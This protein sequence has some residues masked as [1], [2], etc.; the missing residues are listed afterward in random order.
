MRGYSL[1]GLGSGVLFGVMDGIINAN[2][3]GQRLYEVY[4]PI[5]RTSINAPAGVV[6]DLLYGFVL[7]GLFLLLH[8]SLP[9]KSG[10]MKGLSF[11]LLAWF[12]RVLMNAA[13]Q[14]IMFR[15][16]TETLAYTLL[17]GLGEMLILGVLYG[18]TL[19]PTE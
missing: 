11:G 16:S 3:L 10:S 2:P 17:A 4:R 19:R 8:K 15:V 9:G 5:A 12:F 13:S 1:V 18:L 14:W 6:V 7:A